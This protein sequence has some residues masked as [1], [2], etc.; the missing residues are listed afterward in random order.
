[1]EDLTARH[2]TPATRVPAA[3]V[4]AKREMVVA[5]VPQGFDARINIRLTPARDIR[6]SPDLLGCQPRQGAPRRDTDIVPLPDDLPK[7]FLDAN[8]HVLD[9]LAQSPANAKLFVERPVE[10]LLKA[11]VNLTR[12][13]Q[14]ALERASHDVGE[15][16]LA[17]P[18]V[19]VVELSVT[20]HAAGRVGSIKPTS[21]SSPP[22]SRPKGPSSRPDRSDPDCGCT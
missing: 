18:G 20:T 14:K 12:A 8:R 7:K 2:P 13:E 16:R 5:K 19:K 17:A 11:G 4:S 15:T 6:I 10:A 1:M 3:D 21:K 22:E 9:W